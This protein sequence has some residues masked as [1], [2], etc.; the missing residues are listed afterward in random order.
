MQH[1]AVFTCAP[2]L[3]SVETG[4]AT[5][6]HLERPVGLTSRQKY[7]V[8]HEASGVTSSPRMRVVE[9]FCSKVFWVNVV[10]INL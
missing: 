4:S 10:I 8:R 1:S 5:L 7:E 9:C 3:C 2:E 6:H